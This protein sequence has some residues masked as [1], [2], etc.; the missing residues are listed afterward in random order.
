[1]IARENPPL[2]IAMEYAKF[3]FVKQAVRSRGGR[4]SG[5]RTKLPHMV[6][7]LPGASVD[8]TTRKP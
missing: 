8:G 7:L 4:L 2:A 5:P 1:M 6:P 3:G